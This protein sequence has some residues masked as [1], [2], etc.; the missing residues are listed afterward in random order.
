MVHVQEIARLDKDTILDPRAT[1]LVLTRGRHNSKRLLKLF[2]R[3][4][5]GE[6]DTQ[7]LSV[8][9]PHDTLWTEMESVATLIAHP[10]KLKVL[11][12]IG[13]NFSI[14]KA[15]KLTEA[16]TTSTLSMLLLHPSGKEM[17]TESCK[18]RRNMLNLLVLCQARQKPR[19]SCT[20]KMRHFPLD[21]LR[22]TSTYLL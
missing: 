20:S 12:L 1:D 4:S 10:G 3:I 11:N 8:C 5:K 21:L 6:M 18:K 13:L 2:K 9:I 15:K 16:F 22:M 14:N 17:S 7:Y 19:I